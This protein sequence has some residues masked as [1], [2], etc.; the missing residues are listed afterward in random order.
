MEAT[1][2]TSQDRHSGKCAISPP[3]VV[4]AAG[5]HN[6]GGMDK[7]NLALAQY[8]VEQGT[9]V[10]AVC[11][12]ADAD[13][14]R[15]PLVTCHLVPM[16]AGSFFLGV[17]LLD[18]QGRRIAR[19]VTRQWPGTRVL[20]NGDSCLWPAIN[21]VHYVHHAWA[22][23]LREGPLW[24]RTK[25]KLAHRMVRGREKSAA[26]LGQI[27]ITNSDRT[28]RDMI[29]RL[30]VM[31]ERVHKV[32]LGAESEWGPITREEK[33]AGRKALGIP[34]GRLVAAFVG[35]LGFE[36]RKGFDVLF[37]TWKTLCA[38]P[39]WN[40]DLLVAGGGNAL[41][42]WRER[43]VESGLGDR[44]RLA[45]FTADVR[46][47]LA[48]TDVLVSPARYEPYGLNVQEAICRGVPA[49]VSA[50]AGVAERYGRQCQPLLLRDPEDRRELVAT[51]RVWRSNPE[52]WLSRFGP[53]GESL[54][55]YGWKDM[56][57]QMVALI[58][59]TES[60]IAPDPTR[61]PRRALSSGTNC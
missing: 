12:T 16:P 20:V 57:R 29:E 5:F 52:Q 2:K 33:A 44:I 9:P 36:N 42:M 3:W 18:F 8:L 17:P 53:F 55:A 58:N 46:R 47:L 11:H 22:P 49:I 51:I 43:V 34:E 45:G 6:H 41:P 4:V 26:R 56:A 25:Q 30:Q 40:V 7:A 14:A 54:R 31:P 27:F 24:F 59:H 48:A 13:F 15:H 39:E 50:E 38:D 21:W 61:P 10:H 28:S 1:L 60:G 19:R 23:D 35:A 32:Y 37:D